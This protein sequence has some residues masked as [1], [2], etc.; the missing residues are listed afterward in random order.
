MKEHKGILFNFFETGMEAVQPSIQEFKWM[1]EKTGMW[2]MKGLQYV[3][4]GDHLTIIKDGE[5][6]ISGPIFDILPWEDDSPLLINREGV[7]LEVK[8]NQFCLND[9]FLHWLPGNIDLALWWDVF[10]E[11]SGTY[12]G[13]LK[14][15]NG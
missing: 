12:E 8:Y 10:F 7:R 15:K 11:H 9:M 3:E 5:E 2:N 13:I 4:P 6:I 14:K 1:D